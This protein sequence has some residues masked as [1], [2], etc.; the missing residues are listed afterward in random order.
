MSPNVALFITF[1]VLAQP[2]NTMPVMHSPDSM[3][4]HDFRAFIS[5]PTTTLCSNILFEYLRIVL[6]QDIVQRLSQQDCFTHAHA[7]CEA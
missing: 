1:F 4:T 5:S 3:M 2:V 6:T 7:L